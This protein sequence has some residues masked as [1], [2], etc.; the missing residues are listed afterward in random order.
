MPFCLLFVQ[1][2]SQKSDKMTRKQHCVNF[3]VPLSQK[4]NQ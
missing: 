3:E 4:E 2:T 1:C